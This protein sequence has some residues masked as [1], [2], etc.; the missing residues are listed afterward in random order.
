MDQYYQKESSKKYVCSST[1][2]IIPFYAHVRFCD[3][4]FPYVWCLF[5][6]FCQPR[7]L[8]LHH[9]THNAFKYIS[10]K[11]YLALN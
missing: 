6:Y 8:S 1:L 5:E 10:M 7:S 4:P 3:T 11:S 2:V 9:L